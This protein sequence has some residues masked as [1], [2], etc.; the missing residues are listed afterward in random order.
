MP[1]TV[2]RPHLQMTPTV[3]AGGVRTLRAPA[4]LA[5]AVAAGVLLG[6]LSQLGQTYL[7]DWLHSLANSGAPWVLAAVGLALFTRTPRNAAIAGA[8][9]LGGLEIGYVLMAALRHFPSATTTVAFWLV[10]AAVFGPL[11]GLSGYY[12]RSGISPWNAVS[13]GFVAGI[14]SGEGLAAYLTIRDTTTPGYWIVQMIVGVVVLGLAGRRTG[15]RWAVPSFLVAVVG[16]LAVIS[17]PV[18]GA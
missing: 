8:L 17:V 9:A 7:P 10:A 12:L 15:L 14:V 1:G 13:A 2:Q 16:L 6:G 5:V 3:D 18:L 4:S 11:A